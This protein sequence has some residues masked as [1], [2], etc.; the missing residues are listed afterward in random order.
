MN[1]NR[2]FYRWDR[3]FYQNRIFSWTVN[4]TPQVRKMQ[5][6]SSLRNERTTET[7]FCIT[8]FEINAL[9]DENRRTFENFHENFRQTKFLFNAF[10]EKKPFWLDWAISSFAEKNEYWLGFFNLNFFGTCPDQD[11]QTKS[12][13]KPGSTK[14]KNLAELDWKFEA[15]TWTGPG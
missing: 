9:L 12:N 10:S 1:Y 4:Y 2:I 11:Q 6:N 13:L 8:A 7:D 5:N 3:L 15:L 14:H